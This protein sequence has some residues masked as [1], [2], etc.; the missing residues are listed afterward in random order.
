MSRFYRAHF[1]GLAMQGGYLQFTTAHLKPIPLP[2]LA[3]LQGAQPLVEAICNRVN[4]LMNAESEE[5]SARLD[6]EIEVR[7]TRLLGADN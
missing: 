1:G 5:E 4:F 3:R 2:S 7:V 6:E